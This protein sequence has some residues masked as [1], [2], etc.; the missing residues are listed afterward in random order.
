M[1]NKIITLPIMREHRPGIENDTI[2]SH[3]SINGESDNSLTLKQFQ[4]GLELLQ[5]A[6]RE[7][8]PDDLLTDSGVVGASAEN[9]GRYKQIVLRAIEIDGEPWLVG[10][11]VATALRYEN[12]TKAIRDHVEKEDKIMGVQNVTPSVKDSMGRNQY[13]TWINESGLYSLTFS[14]HLPDA[15]KFKR[16]VTSEVLP[17]IRK[18]EAAQNPVSTSFWTGQ[19]CKRYNH[20]LQQSLLL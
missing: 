8:L 3:R 18:V 10:K 6:A 14:S 5:E 7:H 15:K 19:L 11:D 13:P 20:A 9:W 4:C 12:P 17:A 16:W 1:G 2:P